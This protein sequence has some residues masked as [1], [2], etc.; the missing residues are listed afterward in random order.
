MISVIIPTY[1]PSEYFGMTLKSIAEQT[2]QD[3]ELLIVLNG[4][5]EPYKSRIEEL[6]SR[7]GLKA[8]LIQ[9]DTPGVSNARNVGIERSNGDYLCFIDDDDYIS[10]T[11]LEEMWKS[12]VQDGVTV[13]NVIMF[14]GAE[15]MPDNHFSNT[16]KSLKNSQNPSLTSVRRL[17]NS[18]WGKLY[19]RDVIADTRFS[20]RLKIGEDG[21]FNFV[22]SRNIRNVRLAGEGAIYYYRIN[23]EGATGKKPPFRKYFRQYLTQ[24]RLIWGAYLSHPAK[25]DTLFFGTRVLALIKYVLS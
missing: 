15:M 9:T 22:L 11:Y 2:F 1:K 23:P 6:L 14:D 10:E 16:Y 3:F 7:L 25:Y 8:V 13:S 18:P 20:T 24:N 17:L 12:R 5:N 4:C 21:V 19:P